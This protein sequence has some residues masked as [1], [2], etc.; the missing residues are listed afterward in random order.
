MCL[1]APLSEAAKSLQR[2]TLSKS[3]KKSLT[4]KLA[5]Y[6]RRIDQNK[7]SRATAGQLQ[8]IVDQAPE[9][10]AAQAAAILAKYQR[11]QEEKLDAAL[12][13]LAPW[14][15]PGV[16]SQHKYPKAS[17]EQVRCLYAQGKLIE[18]IPILQWIAE[19]CPDT[20]QIEAAR[21]AGDICVE[22]HQFERAISFYRWALKLI[23]VHWPYP[24]VNGADKRLRKEL[25]ALI[26]ETKR[27]CGRRL[28]NAVFLPV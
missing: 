20:T 22:L 13:T 26:K 6:S 8:R 25:Q 28:E 4:R 1:V 16:G 27:R 24:D 14:V 2:R 15:P 23:P 10:L 3:Q 18:A 11:I 12:K 17:L 19:K 5:G 9:P 7:G 21:Y